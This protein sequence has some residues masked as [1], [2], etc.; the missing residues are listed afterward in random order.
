MEILNILSNGDINQLNYE[1]IKTIFKN[2]CRATR[3]RG[4]TSKG[5]ENPP[6]STLITTKEIGGMIED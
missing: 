1:E 6:S 5:L 4:K 3:K 2:D